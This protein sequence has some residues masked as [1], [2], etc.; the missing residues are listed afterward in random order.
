MVNSVKTKKLKIQENL[1]NLQALY[2]CAFRDKKEFINIYVHITICYKLRIFC[3]LC[4][5]IVWTRKHIDRDAHQPATSRQIVRSPTT[6]LI[7]HVPFPMVNNTTV[8]FARF[9]SEKNIVYISDRITSRWCIWCTAR[10]AS[11]CSLVNMFV[12]AEYRITDK[13]GTRAGYVYTT[14]AIIHDFVRQHDSHPL[15]E[16]GTS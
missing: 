4:Q 15:S 16:S 2:P 7:Q 1:A 13:N 10:D 11:S 5:M 6:C 3:V 9:V 12:L 8:H 14:S